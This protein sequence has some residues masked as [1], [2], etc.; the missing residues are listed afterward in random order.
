MTL[1]ESISF[2]R[3]KKMLV[4]I[5]LNGIISKDFA[6]S[7]IDFLLVKCCMSFITNVCAGTRFEGGGAHLEDQ[8]RRTIIYRQSAS[9]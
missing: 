6:L 3:W 2:N 5:C 1:T 8:S 7:D 4:L 9:L